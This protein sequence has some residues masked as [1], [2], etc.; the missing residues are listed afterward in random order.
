MSN[1]HEKFGALRDAMNKRNLERYDEVDIVLTALLAQ[2]HAVLI[3]PPGTAKS[4]LA[5][6]LASAFNGT[7]FKYL[8]GKHTVPEE[9]FGPFKLTA[10]KQDIF[11]RNTEN[12]LPEAHVVFADE[13]FK[14]SSSILNSL[15]TV[16]NEREFD[17]NGRKH[18]PLRTLIAASNELPDGDELLAMFDRF[19]FRK[20]VDYLNEPTN[21]ITLLKGDLN[22]ELPV[23]EL[24]ELNQA[25]EEVGEVTVTDHGYD[26]ILLI[27]DDL[28]HEGI[29]IS[30]RRF[31]QSVTALKAFAWLNGRTVVSDDDFA[32][33]QHMLWTN[34]QEAKTV[35]RI[36]LSRTNEIG[37][38]ADELMDMVDDIASQ[39]SEA[40][41]KM[42][43]DNI[44]DSSKLAKQGIE[45]WRKCKTINKEIQ[46][47]RKEAEAQGRQ[48]NSLEK[49]SDRLSGIMHVVATKVMGLDINLEDTKES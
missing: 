27:R 8:F 38:R 36:I 25:Y 22:A 43:K 1:L 40:L 31:R 47:L 15:L 12:R 7:L 32:I 17:N 37:M 42:R 48:T 44:D 46:G 4:Q 30:D 10:L 16:M 19:H 41:H 26:I 23:L 49:T 28:N 13:V 6:D 29:V 11:E 33:L 9:I 2:Q 18:V 14:G 39:L 20:R 5:N 24:D 35:A 45:W 34:P 21:F 3:G